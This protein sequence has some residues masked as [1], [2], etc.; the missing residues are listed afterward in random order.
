MDSVNSVRRRLSPSRTIARNHYFLSVMPLVV[1]LAFFWPF[2]GGSGQKVQMMSGTL[3]PAAQ[4]TITIRKGKNDNTA[5]NINTQNLAKP[6]SLTPAENVYVVWI[7][8]PG[9]D[10]QNHGMLRVNKNLAGDLET[11]TPYKRF[12]IFITAE[13]NAQIQ[14]PQGPTV[15]SAEVSQS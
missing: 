15:L 14:M 8:P 6:S 13:Q 4:G 10:A 5:V 12:K 7:Q 1:A 11:E 2:G 3:T 9:Q